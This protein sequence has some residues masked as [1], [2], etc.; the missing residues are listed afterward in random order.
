MS[1]STNSNFVTEF[2]GSLFK[3]ILSKKGVDYSTKTIGDFEK[4]LENAFCNEKYDRKEDNVLICPSAFDP[5]R[6][7]K[8]IVVWPMLYSQT[9]F[10]WIL[11]AEI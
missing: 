9:E 3:N 8:R 6:L 4:D 1:I 2:R 5:E 11:T 7:S 10:G